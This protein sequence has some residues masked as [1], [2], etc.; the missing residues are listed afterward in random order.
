MQMTGS[1]SKSQKKD[2]LTIQDVADDI[3][4]LLCN[5]KYRWRQEEYSFGES[6]INMLR[7]VRDGF[8]QGRYGLL[9]ALEMECL[10]IALRDIVEDVNRC[11]TTLLCIKYG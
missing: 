6:A 10:L 7:N 11:Y 3:N 9:D 5:E 4:K 1:R 2:M 8:F